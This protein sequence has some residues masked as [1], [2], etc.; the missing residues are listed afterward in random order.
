MLKP[1]RILQHGDHLILIHIKQHAGKFVI[2]TIGTFA[3]ENRKTA[4]AVRRFQEFL[5]ER[6]AGELMELVRQKE[7]EGAIC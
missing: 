3:K 2:D 7:K 5:A 6:T 1:F 4:N